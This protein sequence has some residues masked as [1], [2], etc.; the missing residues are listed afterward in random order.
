MV[1]RGLIAALSVSVL[2]HGALLASG[3][4]Q[5]SAPASGVS[6]PA[7]VS[8]RLV[9]P[10]AVPQTPV[11]LAP[12]RS[13]PASRAMPDSAASAPASAPAP[14]QLSA[15]EPDVGVVSDAVPDDSWMT[16]AEPVAAGDDAAAEAVRLAQADEGGAPDA[17]SFAI[18]GWPLSGAI[19]YR[20]YLGSG[21][22]Q[23]GEAR[24]EW[25]HDKTRY[26]MQVTLETTGV[27]ALLHGFHYVQKSEGELRPEGLRPQVFTVTQKGKTQESAVFD[28]EHAQVSIR[29]G[30]RER[31]NAVLKPGD[32]DVLSLWHQIGIVGTEGLPRTLMVISN[33]S[34]TPALLESVGEE[35]LRL[36]I[37]QLDTLH[38]RAKAETSELTIDIWLARHYGMLPVRIRVVDDKGEVLDQQAF[39]LRL[40]PP[41]GTA[42]QTAD[43]ADMIEL[44]EEPVLPLAEL[45]TN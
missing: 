38:V 40:E 10:V 34:A 24:H 19:T 23:V 8:A 41:N 11:P 32:Q 33:K 45:S 22:L 28:W 25:S 20:V 1:D 7:L 14:V 17:E 5:W 39:Q 31:K 44:K 3:G 26:S 35:G 37:G 2:A 43:A 36:P 15:L 16:T 42:A 18:D 4:W 27:A 30:E 12:A 21:G 13:K 29:R 9:V 6:A